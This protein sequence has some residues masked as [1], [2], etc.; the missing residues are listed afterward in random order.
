MKAILESELPKFLIISSSIPEYMEK[1]MQIKAGEVCRVA[2]IAEQVKSLKQYVKIYVKRGSNWQYRV[3][4]WQ[5][6]DYLKK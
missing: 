6:L 3:L 4:G 1:Y 2:P 5:H